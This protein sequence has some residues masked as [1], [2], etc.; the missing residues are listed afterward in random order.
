MVVDDPTFGIEVYMIGLVRRVLAIV[1]AH[2][3]KQ[4]MVLVALAAVVS[5]VEAFGTLAIAMLLGLLA[6]RD[7]PVLPILGD[8]RDIAPQLTEDQLLLV[9]GVVVGAFF[10]VRSL[11]I[12]VQYYFQSRI[13][14]T[15]GAR[16][17]TR[18]LAGYLSMP[19]EWHLGRNSSEMVRN[20]WD[21]T[22]RMVS[23]G[24]S[25]GVQVLARV[26]MVL[27][28]TGVLFFTSP[29][30]TLGAAAFIGPVSW[31]VLRIVQPR[32]RRLGRNATAM[33]RANLQ[34]LQECLAGWRDIKVL[35]Q[36][37][38][39]V[40]A[41]ER[42]RT[43]LARARYLKSAAAQVPRVTIE[44]SIVLFIAVYIAVTVSW[45][46]AESA[47]PMLGLFGYA[48][49]RLMP[50]LSTIT[51][52]LNKLKFVGPAIED[53]YADLRS[54][55]D[56]SSAR[57]AELAPCGVQHTLKLEAVSYRYP[58]AS[59]DALANVTLTIAAGQFVGIVGTTGGG[60]S[61]L[62]DI[63]IGLLRPTSGRV[64]LDGADL[65]E[66]VRRWQS[67]IGMVPQTIFVIDDTIRRNVALG[68]PD[69][70]IDDGAVDEALRVAQLDE[71]VSS[72]PAGVDTV[73]G[74]RGTRLSG[75]QRQRL[76][77]AR[78]LY[79]RPSVLIFDEGT[80]AL[81]NDTERALM[82]AL[83][84]VKVGRT[85]ITV[86]HRLTT[87]RK[88]DEVFLISDGR[89]VDVGTFAELEQRHDSLQRSLA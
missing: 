88:C 57:D 25:P 37:A 3:R 82:A 67:S 34:A 44:T 83:D 42:H 20:A 55:E 73:V 65:H 4:W 72:L 33:I 80:S 36:E 53:V 21:S 43:E 39:F 40:H 47:L 50:E 62:T 29:L 14:E 56:L 28:I 13:V 7:D 41:Y 66:V 46:M 38:S 5:A 2:H 74:E 75:G 31:A 15:I 79:R 81:D 76:A 10:V 32:V 8:V 26:F 27:G 86:A 18:L 22:M 12:L 54:F 49:V 17:A 16:V 59:R 51:Q 71:F 78:A 77:I 6:N 87:V 61:T 85:M 58:G 70:D 89:L 64:L 69:E 68:V 48:A 23:E 84:E 52:N 45:D 1:G 11:L 19:A 30:A 63:L 35:G 9:L 60:K 24:L